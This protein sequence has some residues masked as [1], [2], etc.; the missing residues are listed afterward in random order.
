MF[1][2]QVETGNKLKWSEKTCFY[3]PSWFSFTE[4]E[5]NRKSQSEVNDSSDTDVWASCIAATGQHKCHTCSLFPPL[6]LPWPAHLTQVTASI[7]AA[8]LA[9]CWYHSITAS[10]VSKWHNCLKMILMVIDVEFMRNEMGIVSVLFS[11]YL[12]KRH[13]L[14]CS[15]VVVGII[16]SITEINELLLA[17][18]HVMHQRLQ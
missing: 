4:H 8:L 14:V 15:T 10:S 3:W 5:K 17:R 13:A 18:V 12:H 2:N 6:C 1:S 16:F 9:V 11:C 7:L